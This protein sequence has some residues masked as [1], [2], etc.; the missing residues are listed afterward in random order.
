M[1]E[2]VILVGFM[3]SGKSTVGRLLADRLRWGFID[4]DEA[5]EKAQGRTIADI[6]RRH[7]EAYFRA[8][9]ADFT[10]EV[11]GVRQ[12]VLA[13]GGGWVTQP[14]L[15]KQLRLDSLLVWLKV[16]AE[17]VLERHRRQASVERPLLAVENPLEVIRSTLSARERF[18]READAVLDTDDR[19]QERLAE[20]IAALVQRRQE[21]DG[22]EAIPLTSR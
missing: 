21:S 15:V 18:Y 17:G 16:S 6:F 5:I 12:V 14:Q 2:R 10:A 7:G 3:C 22:R 19:D 8:L 9:E 1:I 11:Q 20:E 13:P 4:F